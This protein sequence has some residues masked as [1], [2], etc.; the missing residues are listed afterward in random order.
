[1]KTSIDFPDDLRGVFAVPP[2]CRRLNHSRAIDFDQ[3]RLLVGHIRSGGIT[4]LIY[5]GNAFL[6]HTT[7][8]EYALLLDWLA[9]LDDDLWI[10]PGVG[11]SFGRAL[12]QAHVI[13]AFKFPCAMALPCNDPRDAKG[14]EEGYREIA[15]V[16]ATKLLLYLKDETSFGFDRERGLDA[17]GRLV[18]DGVCIGIKYAV[19]RENPAQDDYL[20]SLLKRVDRSLVISGIGERPAVTHLR[21]WKLPGFTTGSGCIAPRLSGRLFDACTGGDFEAAE[22]LRSEFIPLE[23]RRDAW[24][25]AQVLHAAVEQAGIAYA[26]PIPP[27]VSALSVAQIEKLAPLARELFRRNAMS[28]E[29][30]FVADRVA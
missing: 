11:P 6:Y 26:G 7:H 24:G 20:D 25:P 14:L 10:I 13:R 23:D 19:V 5:G 15:E 4:R 17:V 28:G 12:D 27:F 18:D 16:A 1:M 3:N 8:D 22:Q 30:Q 2:V 29:L 21:E 9:D